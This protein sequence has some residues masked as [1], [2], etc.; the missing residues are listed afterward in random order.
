[1]QSLMRNA[2]PASAP[3]MPPAPHANAH[4]PNATNLSVLEAAWQSAPVAPGVIPPSL[5]SIFLAP[6][7]APQSFAV[8]QGPIPTYVPFDPRLRGNMMPYAPPTAGPYPAPVLRVPPGQGFALPAQPRLPSVIADPD[9]RRVITC[10]Q[11]GSVMKGPC[12]LQ[13][14]LSYS[15]IQSIK[16]RRNGR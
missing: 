5:P 11:C 12:S 13:K 4:P 1:M 6:P 7:T 2:H 8:P 16:T 14:C 9:G 3:R 10:S 15:S